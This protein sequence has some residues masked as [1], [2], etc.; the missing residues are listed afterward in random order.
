MDY[1]LI[2]CFYFLYKYLQIVGFMCNP[3]YCTYVIGTKMY[4][5][6]DCLHRL[7]VIDTL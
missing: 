1:S 7:A 3:V 5:F 2:N 6:Y 4:C